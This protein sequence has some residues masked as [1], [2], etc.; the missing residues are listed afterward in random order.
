MLFCKW[1]ILS[2]FTFYKQEEEDSDEDHSQSSHEL[3]SGPISCLPIDEHLCY[4]QEESE[5]AYVS[6]PNEKKTLRQTALSMSNLHEAT[7]WVLSFCHRYFE[8]L[9]IGFIN[10][11][12][13]VNAQSV[14]TR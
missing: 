6:P 1:L 12:Q 3:S 2:C 8:M 14:P 9:C 5:P 7:M 11:A 13:F 4:S 10:E